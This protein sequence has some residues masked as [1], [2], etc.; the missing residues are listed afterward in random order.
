MHYRG[1]VRVVRR[2]RGIRVDAPREH[3]IVPD[4]AM[5]DVYLAEV[6][7]VAHRRFETT[8]CSWSEDRALH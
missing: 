1:L 2:D 5:R 4:A 6:F 3:A 7:S 8:A